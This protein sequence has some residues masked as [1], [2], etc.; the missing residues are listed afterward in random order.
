[1]PVNFLSESALGS[2]RTGWAV[3]GGLE[4]MFAPGWSVFGEYDYMDFGRWNIGYVVG[5]KPFRGAS[6]TFCRPA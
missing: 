5:R 4:W 3:G 2:D 6:G 1:M